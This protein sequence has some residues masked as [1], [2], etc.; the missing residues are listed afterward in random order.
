MDDR[1][2]LMTETCVKTMLESLKYKFPMLVYPINLLKPKATNEKYDTMFVTDGEYLMF[3]CQEFF[4][5]YCGG[6]KIFLEWDILHIVLHGL[7]GHFATYSKYTK[8]KLIEVV[9]DREVLHLEREMCNGAEYE[10]IIEWWDACDEDSMS[11]YLGDS[12]DIGN[13]YKASKNKVLYQRMLRDGKKIRRD[14]H[15]HWLKPKR[16][17][18]EGGTLEE[19]KSRQQE[20]AKKWDTAFMIVTGSS[21]KDKEMDKG[22]TIGEA[23]KSGMWG[24][25]SGRGGNLVKATEGKGQSY[26]EILMNFIKSRYAANE[27]MSSIDKMLYSYGLDL[28]GD[29]P[30]IEPD[31]EGETFQFNTICIAIDTSGS[32]CGKTAQRFLT[33]TAS[34]LDGIKQLC[35]KG[36]IY[37]F[38]CD[39]QLQKEDYYGEIG[40]IEVED[41]KEQKLYGFGGTSFVP[42]FDRID[43]LTKEGK[44]IDALIY[45]SDGMGNYPTEK[46]EYPVCFVLPGKMDNRFDYIPDWI[47]TVELKKEGD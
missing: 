32:C 39:A 38:Q 1:D 16:G 4:R 3:N 27:D 5:C 37:L 11:S 20:I 14:D 36:E 42:V 44:E 46:P 30:L 15:S 18:G 22:K 28:Y 35:T 24:S 31:E 8:K 26:R 23:I 12:F 47:E 45:L 2:I 9:M 43:E 41:W 21:T 25:T 7:L 33:E 6:E 10:N 29:V 19:E 34:V 40:E 13:Y 17:K